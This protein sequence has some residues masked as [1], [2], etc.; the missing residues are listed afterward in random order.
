MRKSLL[1][2]TASLFGMAPA[3]HASNDIDL[4]GI[5]NQR[6]FN[7]L[8]DQ[9]GTAIAYNPV[10]PAEPL[11]ITGFE[12]GVAVTAFDL[13][14]DVWDQAVR[15]RD[16]PSLLPAPRLIARKGLPAGFDIGASW[17]SVPGSNISVWGGELRKALLEGYA[18]HCGNGTLQPV[19]RRRRSAP[20][21][22]RRGSVDQQGVCNADALRRHRACMV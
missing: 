4:S 22:L 14:D 13:D 3:L 18:R 21:Q 20:F 17:T 2:V 7:S 16:A 6:T 19:E 10:T 1:I 15:D 8:I 9:L 11:G 12:I 5:A